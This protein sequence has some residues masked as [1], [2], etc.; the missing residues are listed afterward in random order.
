MEL[1]NVPI[2]TRDLSEGND[3]QRWAIDNNSKIRSFTEHD[4]E[5]ITSNYSTPIGKGGFGEVFK[6]FLD[7]DDYDDAVA[8]KRYIRSELREEFMEEVSIHSKIDYKNVVK[9]LGCSAGENTLTMVTEFISNGNLEDA[10]HKSDISIS[11]NTRLG[12]A[13]GCAE[14][15]SYMHSMHSLVDLDSLVCHGDI[16]P[17]NILLNENFTAKLSDF[18]LSRLLLGGITRS[19]N[20]VKGSMDY[21]DPIYLYTGRITRKSDVYSFGIVLLELITR[22]RV[23]A[24]GNNLIETFSKA[25]AKGNVVS[26]EIFDAEIAQGSNTKILEVIGKLATECVTLDIDKR[27]QMNNV[28]KRLMVL[29]KALRGGDRSISRRFFWRTENDLDTGSGQGISSIRST[30]SMLR[31]LGISLRKPSNYE[32][33]PELWNVKTFTKGEVIEFTENYSYLI[34]KGWSS[35][36]YKGTLEDNTLVAVMKSHEANDDQRKDFSNAAIVQSQTIHKN[37]IK[38]LGYCFEDDIIVLVYEYAAKG[39]LSTILHGEEDLPLESRLKIA[40]KTAEALSHNHSCVIQH[41]SVTTNNILHGSVTTPNILIDS[42]FVPKL[43]GFSL[44]RSPI[45][46]NDGASF[47]SDNM[48]YFDPSFPKYVKLTVKTDVYSFGLV[49]L[50]L[51]SRKKP[52]Y[53]EG[54][55]RLVSEFIRAYDRDGSGHAMFDERIRTQENI[56]A[57]EE[58]G[59]L[60]LRCSSLE[61][62]ARPTM[63][64]VAGRLEMI[65]S[66]WK[67]ST[68]M[69]ATSSFSQC[70]TF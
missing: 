32:I 57:L 47:G 41:G 28:A 29:W 54:N 24:G 67:Q 65:R 51:I 13:I 63:K 35:D 37:I 30:S 46:D 59:R 2:K 39:N 8:V 38:L 55:N 6:G 66:S 61:T 14:A 56:P 43:A 33:I 62:N 10:L 25:F 64:E 7:D 58:I 50:E 60:G 11:L 19:T 69:R 40:V 12:I 36:V 18:G 26:R 17:A 9:L 31:R 21:M 42:N 45:G 20:T 48:N 44:S 52:V 49:L 22:K 5:R 68:A 70:K 16:K 3:E 15:L 27:P 1:P 53:Q 23:K 4:I 34:G